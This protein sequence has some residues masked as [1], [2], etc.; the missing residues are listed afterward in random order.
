MSAI[1]KLI[2]PWLGRNGVLAASIAAIL[3]LIMTWDKS[4]VETG[5]AQERAA[6]IEKGVALNAKGLAAHE[7]AGRPGAFERLRQKYCIDC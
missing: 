2:G 3:A 1:W 7:L 5:R 6:Q 4:R